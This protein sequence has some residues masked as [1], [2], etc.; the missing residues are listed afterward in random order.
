M[1]FLFFSASKG[2]LLTYI[3]PCFAPLSILLAVGLER[4][5]GAGLRRAY[6]IGAAV[7]CRRY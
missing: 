1:P 2:K 6:S 4:Y 5:L 3:L 7:A